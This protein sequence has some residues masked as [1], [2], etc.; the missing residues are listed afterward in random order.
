MARIST[1][2][3]GS[4]GTLNGRGFT[5]VAQGV[6]TLVEWDND[7][8]C[9][10]LPGTTE[11]T[12]VSTGSGETP[13][14]EKLMSAIRKVRDTAPTVW[15]VAATAQPVATEAGIGA[16]WRTMV[17][18]RTTSAA[19]AARNAAMERGAYMLADAAIALEYLTHDESNT[20]RQT[21]ARNRLTAL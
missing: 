8:L 5:V 3:N 7:D 11:A 9:A 1:F 21:V 12:L 13:S 20:R 16:E 14:T 17:T 6:T 18:E 19:K 2:P 4:T 15:E 10:M